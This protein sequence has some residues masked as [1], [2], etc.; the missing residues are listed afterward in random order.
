MEHLKVT[1]RG[2]TRTVIM[3]MQLDEL[4]KTDEENT[5]AKSSSLLTLHSTT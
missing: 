5:T 3:T 1:L 2:E 4:R